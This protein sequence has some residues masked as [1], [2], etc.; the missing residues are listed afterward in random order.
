MEA[1][2]FGVVE[3]E[4]EAAPGEADTGEPVRTR[5]KSQGT[6]N[7]ISSFTK[8][9]LKS[10]DRNLEITEKARLFYDSLDAAAEVVARAMHN[11]LLPEPSEDGFD[12]LFIDTVRMHA[13]LPDIRS[14]RKAAALSHTPYVENYETRQAIE[15]LKRYIDSVAS[16]ENLLETIRTLGNGLATT[17]KTRRGDSEVTRIAPGGTSTDANRFRAAFESAKSEIVRLIGADHELY[18]ASITGDRT[19]K[20]WRSG[21]PVDARDAA[22]QV[23]HVVAPHLDASGNIRFIRPSTSKEK[24]RSHGLRMLNY[25]ARATWYASDARQAP[26]SITQLFSRLL[27]QHLDRY[28]KLPASA[29]RTTLMDIAILGGL[30][31]RTFFDLW[32][33][34]TVDSALSKEKIYRAYAYNIRNFCH[35]GSDG[36]QF[37]KYKNGRKQQEVMFQ[38]FWVRSSA[39]IDRLRPIDALGSQSVQS[40]LYMRTLPEP[41]V[42]RLPGVTRPY[43]MPKTIFGIGGRY[44]DEA[45]ASAKFNEELYDE[46]EDDEDD[47]D[48]DYDDI[49]EHHKQM[50]DD[51]AHGIDPAINN[52]YDDHSVDDYVQEDFGRD[53]LEEL[54]TQQNWS[55]GDIL[56]EAGVQFAAEG[57]DGMKNLP[58]LQPYLMACISKGA[59]AYIHAVRH[60]TSVQS[61]PLHEDIKLFRELFARLVAN[62]LVLA[63]EVAPST[64]RYFWERNVT[65]MKFQRVEILQ[66]IAQLC[67]TV[68]PVDVDPFLTGRSASASVSGL[69]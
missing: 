46:D 64:N 49:E 30:N 47:S 35:S 12:H 3:E 28:D 53:E 5:S 4:K 27:L 29:R 26:G 23:A 8:S 61:Q 39:V 6:R 48:S 43:P 54:E 37:R 60:V 11:P 51:E 32:A 56:T 15:D 24:I 42:V 63:R 9:F 22:H 7:I 21:L 44:R 50:E 55:L 52:Q 41:E 57:E 34:F 31:P 62:K 40:W 13:N 1:V 58:E 17:V 25:P 36:K 38:Q 19:R 16:E 20:K 33:W 65:E 67:G 14:R 45:T 69:Y 2:R 68:P 10:L 66:Q 59:K 18:V